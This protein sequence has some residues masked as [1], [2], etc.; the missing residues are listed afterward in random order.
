MPG[1]PGGA[2]G[3]GAAPARALGVLT[4]F[5]VLVAGVL[6][7]MRHGPLEVPQEKGGKEGTP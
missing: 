1:C 3:R 6:H 4:M 5:S 2:A 7:Y